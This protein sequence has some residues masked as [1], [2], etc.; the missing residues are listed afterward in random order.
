MPE[1]EQ[2]C[3]AWSGGSCG[4]WEAR[5][6]MARVVL[7]APEVVAKI[8]RCSEAVGLWGIS[9][10]GISDLAELQWLSLGVI[11]SVVVS[12][13]RDR[14][15]VLFPTLC[16]H[17]YTPL[18]KLPLSDVHPSTVFLPQMEHEEVTPPALKQ[19]I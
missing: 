13:C 1:I 15:S 9:D 4:I 12:L 6:V 11:I 8:E 16:I 5:S 17:A 18:F 10:L 19:S 7:W 14:I 2:D 3:R